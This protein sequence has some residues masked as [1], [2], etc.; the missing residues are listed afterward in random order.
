LSFSSAVIGLRFVAMLV[1][2]SWVYL[3]HKKRKLIKLK[4]SFFLQN[5]GL[6]LQQQLSKQQGSREMAKIFTIEE[7]KK[8]THNYEESR[9]IG[10]GGF[11]T[12]YKGILPDKRI[13]A[14]KKS[15]TVDQNQIDQF[16]NE[17]VLLSQINHKNV[18]KLLGCCLKTQVPLLASL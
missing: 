4:E 14:I 11:G 13:V 1:G 5:E 17:V 12:V 10:Q 2:S 16:V 9:I 3:I 15:K 6:I 8:A 7:L 18:V